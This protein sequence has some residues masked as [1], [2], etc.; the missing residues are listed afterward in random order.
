MSVTTQQAEK[1][2]KGNYSFSQLGFSLMITRLKGVYSRSPSQETLKNC[3][4]EIN[5]FLSKFQTIMKQDYATI[6]KI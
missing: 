3:A 4:E 1:I 6:A 2:L 5:T